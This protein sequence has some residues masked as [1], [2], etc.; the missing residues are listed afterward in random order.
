MGAP[1]LK[2][3]FDSKTPAKQE[4]PVY[5][6][7]P[8]IPDYERVKP[9]IQSKRLY[10]SMESAARLTPYDNPEDANHFIPSNN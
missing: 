2:L 8:P 7:P 6:S 10:S 1:N 5:K 4:T 9:E 3:V